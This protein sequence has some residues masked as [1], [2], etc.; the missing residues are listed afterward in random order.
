MTGDAKRTHSLGK[1]RERKKKNA[2]AVKWKATTE[3]KGVVY[4]TFNFTWLHIVS[5]VFENIGIILATHNNNSNRAKKWREKKTRI[6]YNGIYYL[7][8]S[9]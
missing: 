5:D 3:T 6:V 4:D 8:R 9:E 1:M 2:A 7:F